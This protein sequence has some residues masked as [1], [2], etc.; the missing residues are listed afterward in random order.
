MMAKSAQSAERRWAASEA[1]FQPEDFLNI[2]WDVDMC[3]QERG[4]G[5]HL[6]TVGSHRSYARTN[7]HHPANNQT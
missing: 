6:P 7:P 1:I 5:M 3:D 2:L 4:V